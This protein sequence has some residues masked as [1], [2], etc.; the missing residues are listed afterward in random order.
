MAGRMKKL[1]QCLNKEY[2]SNM[3]MQVGKVER[4]V[5]LLTLHN[6]L[7][8]KRILVGLDQCADTYLDR[9]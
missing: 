2:T 5:D 9:K 3:E 1:N 6:H 4:I 8:Y 7:I